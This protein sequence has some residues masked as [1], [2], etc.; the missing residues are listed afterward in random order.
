[1]VDVGSWEIFGVSC[2]QALRSLLRVDIR[3]GG[4]GGGRLSAAQDFTPRTGWSSA[5]LSS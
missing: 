2:F 4:G 3:G 5:T 1:M